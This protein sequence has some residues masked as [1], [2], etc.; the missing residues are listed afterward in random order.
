MKNGQSLFE[1]IIALA[2][3]AIVI[4]AVVGLTANSIR[5]ASFS[6]NKT[7]ASRYASDAVE[8]LRSERDSDIDNF[9]SNSAL[10]YCLPTLS[11]DLARVC[12]DDD[13]IVG[14]P[15]IRAVSFS[16]TSGVTTIV[17]ATVKVYWEDSQGVHDFTTIANFTD[18]RQR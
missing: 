6:R 13:V 17:E 2:V 4:V 3:A 11:W 12:N 9:L 14:T 10:P 8:W 15:F 16:N 18:W 5:N 7:L 1:V